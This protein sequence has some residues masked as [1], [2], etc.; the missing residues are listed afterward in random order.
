MVKIMNEKILS[1]V[2]SFDY[3]DFYE[4]LMD[5]KSY[6]LFEYLFNDIIQENNF[7]I[8]AVVHDWVPRMI[9]APRIVKDPFRLPRA[10][11]GGV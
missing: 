4:E 8:L 9:I 5:E 7:R 1:G 10:L 6:I 3:Y 2:Y 11:S